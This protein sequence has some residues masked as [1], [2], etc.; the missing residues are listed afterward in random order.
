[1]RWRLLL[2]LL[3]ASSGLRAACSTNVQGVFLMTTAAGITDYCGG[4][5]L[6]Q[7]GTVPHNGPGCRSGDADAA[8]KFS[9]SNYY[10][11]PASVDAAMAGTTWW[12]IEHYM[13]ITGNGGG[14]GYESLF[15]NIG[16]TSNLLRMNV[17]ENRLQW[18]NGIVSTDFGSISLNTC[19][20][21]DWVG[22]ATTRK[23]YINNAIALND[24]NV[25]VYANSATTWI[26]KHNGATGY[27]F[28]GYIDGVVLEAG[29]GSAP[30]S[31]PL[32]YDAGTPTFTPTATPTFTSTSTP[33]PSPTFSS[34]AT[35]TA[36]P[37]FSSTSTPTPSPT[38]T[39]TFSSTVTLTF[40]PTFSSTAT[41]TAT[42]TSTSTSSP[43]FTSTITPSAT[44]TSTF[45]A[46]PSITMTSTSTHTPTSTRT[47]TTTPTFTATP[48]KTITATVTPTFTAT[49]SPTM[50][51]TQ[52][53]TATPPPQI[54]VLPANQV[55]KVRF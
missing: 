47:S 10:K 38:F 17:N 12:V 13:Y 33:T 52:T 30:T 15:F 41:P 48:T 50:T 49:P 44:P 22:T 32:T 20:L 8:G 31:F 39:P 2:C 14:N 51:I 37:T 18:N 3:L 4:S 54:R 45:T 42:P 24:G 19:Y 53:R 29:S 55:V 9:D 36:T 46:T 6:T 28:D 27:Y 5:S 1:M 43:T 34:T 25:G 23:V 35:P 40:T 7:V 16:T 26:G 21:V 11:L